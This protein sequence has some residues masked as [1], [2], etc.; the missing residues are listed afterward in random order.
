LENDAFVTLHGRADQA[1]RGQAGRAQ[2]GRCYL[3]KHSIHQWKQRAEG[4]ELTFGFV[5]SSNEIG[6]PSTNTYLG[7]PLLPMDW[8]QFS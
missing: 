2:S 4:E 7:R 1:L 6:L 5:A 3:G 8:L